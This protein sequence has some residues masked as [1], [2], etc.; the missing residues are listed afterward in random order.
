MVTTL[1]RILTLNE[2]RPSLIRKTLV[3]FLFSISAR[4]SIRV[5]RQPVLGEISARETGPGERD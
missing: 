5:P 4:V 3:V 2:N 1:E